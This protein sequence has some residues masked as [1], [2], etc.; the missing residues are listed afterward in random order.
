MDL[1][2]PGNL[3]FL[4]GKTG[5]EFGGSHHHLVTGMSGGEVP[6][7]DAANALAC[8]RALWK[9]MGEGIVR[10]AHDCSEGGLAV[11]LAEMAFAGAPGAEV[12]LSVGLAAEGGADDAA[13][14]FSESLGRIVVE[15]APKNAGELHRLF[16]GLPLTHIG[17]VTKAA[18]LKIAGL[19]GDTLIEAECDELRRIWKEPLFKAV[20]EGVPSDV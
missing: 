13:L 7:L 19:G 10:S 1:K 18:K 20:G 14:L 9:A 4:I 6:R 16:A 11:A 15:V 3:L 2:T 17:T 12:S 8:Y 5:V